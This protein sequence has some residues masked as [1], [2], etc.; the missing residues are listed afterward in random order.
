MR[1]ITFCT[2]ILVCLILLFLYFYIYSIWFCFVNVLY[3]CQTVIS[4]RS[5]LLTGWS[6][7]TWTVPTHRAK[8]SF[9]WRTRPAHPLSSSQSTDGDSG[10]SVVTDGMTVG[11]LRGLE[12]SGVSSDIFDILDVFFLSIRFSL[13][14]HTTELTWTGRTAPSSVVEFNC[15]QCSSYWNHAHMYHCC[16]CNTSSDIE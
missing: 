7:K 6:C 14:G 3:V 11:T 15:C 16:T 9:V 10:D 1:F 13:M 2:W 8:A 5:N 12:S 4:K